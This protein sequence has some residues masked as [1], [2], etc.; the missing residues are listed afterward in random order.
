MKGHKMKKTIHFVGFRTDAQY[1]AAVKV[2]GKPDFIHLIHDH[3]MY[4]D[5]GF[6]IDPKTET[7]VFGEKGRDKPDPNYNDQ[8]HMRH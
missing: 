7:V 2:F 4:G 3:R 8:D 6:P 1:S 5:T